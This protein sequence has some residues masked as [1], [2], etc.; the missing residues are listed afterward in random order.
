MRN[1][2]PGE[3]YPLG[4]TCDGSGT[5]FSIFSEVAE[6]VQLCLFDENGKE[7]QLDL[8]EKHGFCWHGYLPE[9]GPGQRYGYRI[10]GPWDPAQGHRCNPAKLL[11]DPYAKS[12][13]G[14]LQ[15]HKAVFPYEKPEPLSPPEKNDNA[16]LVPKSVVTEQ[17]F[18][19]GGVEKPATALHETLIYELHVKGFTA[20]NPDIPPEIR[21]TYQALAHPAAI[22]YLKELGVTAIELMPVHQ[23]VHNH[24]LV[25]RG[26]ANYWGYNSIG[27]FAPHNEYASAAQAGQQVQQ[28]KQMI[29]NLHQAGLEVIL[30]V[31]Y[32]HTAEGNHLGPV[33]CFKGI[34]NRAYYRLKQ[35]QPQ[36]YMDYTGTGNSLNMRSP[37]TLQLVMDSLR[38]W[39]NQMQV[40]GF[41]FDMAPVLAR[42]LHDVDRLSSFFDIIHQDPL[43][44]QVKLIAEPWDIGEGG[45]QVGKFPTKWSEWNGR[46]RDCVRDYWRTQ[47][48]ILGEFAKRF[49]GSSDLYESTGRKPFASVNFVTCHDGFT[50]YDLVSYNQKHNEEN[51]EDN[52]D[53]IDDNRSWNCGHEGETDNKDIINLRERQMRNFLTTLLLS[54]GIPMILQG[55][56]LART[57]NGNN[58]AY[59]QDNQISWLNWDNKNAPLR[60]FVSDLIKFRKQHP[61]FSRR[62]WFQGRDIWSKGIKDIGWYRP[63]GREMA[64]QDWQSDADKALA[65]YLTGHLDTPGPRGEHI[66]DND[67]CIM[68]NNGEKEIEFRIPARGSDGNWQKVIDTS[69]PELEKTDQ[70]YKDGQTVNVN[71]R[72]LVVFT[73]PVTS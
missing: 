28:F 55:D 14:P 48:N 65:V 43:L 33:L 73:N 57:Q 16:H 20:L 27:F 70:S 6:K 68:F 22:E 61:A 66:I 19:W 13:E 31:V 49:S 18:D 69:T 23:F 24:Y 32:N 64:E 71:G 39:A 51:K 36:Y 4:A 38:Y 35:E 56:E 34:D 60:R 72:S 15:W 5:N 40:D 53:G 8:P 44:N 67:F 45:Y 29:K 62:D 58:N 46:Y 37:N 21:G 2:W 10:H 54:Q 52:K 26:L 30:D 50:L 47:P 9:I 63:D 12:I 17:S 59:C 1:I 25:E 11:I 41:R 3:A 42:E 7:T